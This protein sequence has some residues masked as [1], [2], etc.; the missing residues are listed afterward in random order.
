MTSDMVWELQKEPFQKA[1]FERNRRRAPVGYL[2]RRRE[3]YFEPN[4]PDVRT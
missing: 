1:D 4:L 2:G 3:P